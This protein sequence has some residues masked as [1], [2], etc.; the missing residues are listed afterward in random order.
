MKKGSQNERSSVLKIEFSNRR[1]LYG[2]AHDDTADLSARLQQSRV[3]LA[4]ITQVLAASEQHSAAT[5]K[6]L[7][8]LAETNL[9]LRQKLIGVEKEAATA[10]HLAYHDVLTGLPNRRLLLDRLNQAIAQASR[11]KKRVALVFFDVDGFKTIND[12]FRTYRRRQAPASCGGAFM[13]LSACGGYSL[14][15]WGRRVHR[16]AAGSRRRAERGGGRTENPRPVGRTL[17]YRWH[18][19]YRHAQY[20][21][22]RVSRGRERSPRFNKTGRYR[23]V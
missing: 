14:P 17:P 4:E 18:A 11:Q 3:A 13:C 10:N 15:V 2:S 12:K 22:R 1:H 19:D 16:H 23:H 21:Y 7:E 20:R 5:L 9:Y 6:K 8:T